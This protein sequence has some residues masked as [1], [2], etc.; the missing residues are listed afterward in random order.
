[1]TF[2]QSI[3]P[4]H[5][6]ERGLKRADGSQYSPDEMAQ[7]IAQRVRNGLRSA[8]DSNKRA[9]SPTQCVLGNIAVSPSKSVTYLL[10]YFYDLKHWY[11]FCKQDTTRKRG[12]A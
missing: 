5:L 3:G 7:A 9:F 4:R 10:F 12:D 6:C 2:E 1:M 8:C 11:M